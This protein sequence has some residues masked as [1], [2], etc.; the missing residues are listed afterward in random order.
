MVSIRPVAA[1]LLLLC[2]SAQAE[3]QTKL[4]D[5]GPAVISGYVRFVNA[6]PAGVTVTA[7]G[8][9]SLALDPGA[10]GRFQAVPAGRELTAAIAAGSATGTIAVTLQADEFVT[11]AVL[12][13]ATALVLR[14][15]PQDFNALKAD[16][17][18]LNADPGC[19]GAVMKAGA[20]KTVVFSDIAPGAIARRSVNPVAAVIEAACGDQA[21]PGS[22]DL[23]TLGAGGRYSIIVV[24][25]AGGTHRLIGGLDERAKY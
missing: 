25:G 19:T 8:T 20:K 4:Y 16:I 15:R 24:P 6:A 14:D 9:G 17:A 2:G 10:I 13:G 1:L 18:F 12:D 23:G 22:L 5:T 11:I 3:E 21:V 7:G